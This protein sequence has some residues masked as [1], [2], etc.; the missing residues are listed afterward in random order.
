MHRRTIGALAAL[1]LAALP[2]ARAQDLGPELNF[3][4]DEAQDASS[5]DQ[6][7]ATIAPGGPGFLVVWQDERTDTTSSTLALGQAYSGNLIDIYAAR[8]DQDGKRLDEAPLVIANQG[9]DQVRPTASWNGSE[10][11]VVFETQQPDWYFNRNIVGVRVSGDGTVLDADPILIRQEK[12]SP[13]ND[14]G[15]E[16]AVSSDGTNWFVVWTGFDFA[17]NKQMMEGT[18]IDASGTL[19][20]PNYKRLYTWTDPVFGPE[21]PQIGFLGGEYL[22]VWNDLHVVRTLRLDTALNA[23][24]PVKTVP[25]LWDDVRLATGPPGHLL[26]IADWAVRLAPDGTL[27]DTIPIVFPKIT[28]TGGQIVPPDTY[29]AVWNGSSWSL[30]YSARPDGQFSIGD[31][32]VYLTRIG[33]NGSILDPTPIAVTSGPADDEAVRLAGLGDGRTLFAY[34]SHPDGFGSLEDVVTTTVDAS[35]NPQAAEVASAGLNR[36]EHLT[37][38]ENGDVR[39]AVWVSRSAGQ[40]RILAQ[41]FDQN[42]SPIDSDAT[43]VNQDSELVNSKPSVVWNGSHYLIVWLDGGRTVRGKRLDAGL[44]PVDATPVALMTQMDGAPSVGSHNGDYLVAASRI[45][46]LDISTLYGLRIDGQAWTP[47]DP[48]P[49]VIAPNYSTNPVVAAL[50]G[51]YLVAYDN[52]G[53]HNCSNHHVFA[54]QV[55][56]AGVVGGPI[57]IDGPGKAGGADIAVADDRALITYSDPVVFNHIALEGRIV[58]ADGS[59]P[60]GEILIANENNAQVGGSCVWDGDQFVVAWTDYRQ[61][62]GIEQRRG[63]IYM[64]R[65]ALDGTLIDPP[66]GVQVT[67]G[68]LPE[69]RAAVTGGGGTAII[70]YAKLGKVGGSP[71]VQ[72]NTYRVLNGEVCQPDLGFGGPGA[73]HLEL[74]G[75][76]LASGLSATLRLSGAPTAAPVGLLVGLSSNPS[77]LLGG[78]VVPSPLQL[79]PWGSTDFEGKVEIGPIQGGGGPFSLFVQAALLDLSQPGL[80]GFSNA[81]EAQFLP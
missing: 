72:R 53:C 69:D 75:D 56:P 1:F 78:T 74:C 35:G 68:E 17:L 64:S 13:A 61:N 15:K 55:S 62:H 37:W 44:Q 18:R 29:D 73:S 58:M 80:V 36:Q 79:L 81:I 67:N 26:M 70:G 66:G 24:G 49:F 39:L 14:Y 63:D 57:Q 41:R 3:P 65:L 23:L 21:N 38:A 4:G 7:N 48:T 22:L 33:A 34:D 5:A 43:L 50:G 30:G 9:M 19:L 31:H 6:L 71:E 25:N 76:P 12:S 20:D 45:T 2:F 16:P 11:L 10:W 8:Y 51:K 46:S 40:S 60:S 28:T 47:L 32:N 59:L 77:P 42:G 52:V 27:L 54:R